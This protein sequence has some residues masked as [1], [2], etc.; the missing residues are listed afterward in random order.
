MSSIDQL[1]Y[2]QMGIFHPLIGILD[3]VLDLEN[4][5][6]ELNFQDVISRLKEVWAAFLKKKEIA[7]TALHNRRLF[8][9]AAE[10]ENRAHLKK[11]IGII[12][13]IWSRCYH[14]CRLNQALVLKNKA[15]A[16][17]RSNL[18]ECQFLHLE[19]VLQDTQF[20]IE[21]SG[22]KLWTPVEYSPLEA[23]PIEPHDMAVVELAASSE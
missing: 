6:E 15:L 14:R 5:I 12:N 2:P 8:T 19:K 13:A 1:T 20:V 21:E 11:I 7:D 23:L 18:N 16:F 17:D 3:Q 9:K 22:K 10:G 4:H